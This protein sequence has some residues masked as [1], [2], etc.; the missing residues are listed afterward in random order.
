MSTSRIDQKRYHHGDLRNTLIA[1]ALEMLLE[2]GAAALSLR[3]LA[4]RA[5]V[6]HNA[7][8]QHFTDK[9]ALMAAIAEQG[10][11]I[12][13]GHI[14]S[15]QEALGGWDSQTRLIAAG[16]SYVR[17]A[18]EHPGHLQVMFGPL[19]SSQYPTLAQAAHAALERLI[20]I[21]AQ[22][23][24]SGEIRV[25][26]SEAA[27]TIWMLVHGLSSTFIAQKLP[28]VIIQERTPLAL[29]ETYLRLACEGLVREGDNSSLTSQTIVKE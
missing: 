23:Q 13:A 12:L 29:A 25:D 17:F 18:I 20:A 6:S 24:A 14:D 1:T 11:R 26:A 7:P 15:S 5:G 8:Y 9:E 16:Q 3:G 28:D 4:K 10:F 2:E 19:A 27:M 21:A 22:G